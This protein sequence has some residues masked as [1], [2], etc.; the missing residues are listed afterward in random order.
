MKNTFNKLAGYKIYTQNQCPP[1]TTMANIF[2]EK[3]KKTIL[4]TIA[5][6]EIYYLGI[7]L[8]KEVKD[9]FNVKFKTWKNTI[10]ED[11]RKWEGLLCL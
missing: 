2:R 6:K 7:N 10:K 8:T 3:I 9:L 11:T 1:G 4:F 5:S